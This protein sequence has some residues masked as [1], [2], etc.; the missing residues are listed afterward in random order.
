MP[1]ILGILMSVTITSYRAPSILFF[2]ACPDCTVSTRWPSRRR[3]ISSISQMERSSSQTRMLATHPSSRCDCSLMSEHGGRSLKGSMRGRRP[4]QNSFLRIQTPQPQDESRA[5][6]RFR[7]RPDLAFVGLHNLINNGQPQASAAFK[8][9]LE[10][11]EDFFRLLRTHSRT[12]VGE[13]HLPVVAERLDA[14]RELPAAAHGA[15]RVFTKIPEDLFDLVAVSDGKSFGHRE[16]ALDGDPGFFRGHAVVHQ[17]K[18]VFDQLDQIRSD[19]VVLLGT[20]V[21]Q[22]IGNDAVQSL[23]LAGHNPQQVPVLFVHFWNAREH[24]HRPS[25]RSQRIPNFMR[26]SGGQPAYGGEPL[27]PAPFPLPAPGTR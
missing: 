7:A 1:S 9:R 21:S 20:G 4:R 26:D 2:A 14:D 3:A 15:N 6:P 17:R 8:I 5:L 23:R 25:D 24:A 16:P 10:G 12:G 11:L 18:G 27:P 19:E 22:K 13:S